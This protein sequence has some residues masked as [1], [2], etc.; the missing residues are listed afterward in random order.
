MRVRRK[1]FTYQLTLSVNESVW[2]AENRLRAVRAKVAGKHL[3]HAGL[4]TKYMFATRYGKQA[5]T[6]RTE[7]IDFAVF[8]HKRNNLVP[9]V[10]YRWDFNH[11]L[12]HRIEVMNNLYAPISCLISQAC[13][14]LSAWYNPGHKRTSLLNLIRGPYFDRWL[15]RH[16]VNEKQRCWCSGP[17]L[18]R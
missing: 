10:V 14:F 17:L 15:D 2:F 13:I 11:C 5:P 1:W 3:G 4:T 16:W 6:K 18:S 12:Q 7:P 8:K 9:R